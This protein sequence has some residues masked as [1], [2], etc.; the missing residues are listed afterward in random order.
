MLDPV[1]I[2]TFAAL[3]VAFAIGVAILARW[4]GLKPSRLAA[5][6]LIASS[7][8]FVGLAFG[9]ESANSWVAVEMTAVAIFGSAAVLALMFSPW[10]AIAG[11]LLHPIWSIFVH[12]RGAGSVFTPGPVAVAD[13]AFDVVLS[14]I[15]AFFLWR[16]ASAA[17]AGTGDAAANSNRK[18]GKG[19]R[20]A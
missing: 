5:Y 12:Y 18:S 13:A 14:L 11:L 9:S 6:A 1:E 3:G 17:K 15:L 10:I 19:K 7:F 8:L 20:A 4:A 2:A 16:G